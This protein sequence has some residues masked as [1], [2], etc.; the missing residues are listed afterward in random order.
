MKTGGGGGGGGVQPTCFFFNPEQTTPLIFSFSFFL[1]SWEG[2][3]VVLNFLCLFECF[4]V[5]VIVVVWSYH[6]MCLRQR[7]S[8]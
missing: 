7:A 3:G 8:N 6:V 4:V 5:V 1:F 2:R